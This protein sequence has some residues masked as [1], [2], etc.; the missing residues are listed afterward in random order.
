MMIWA[1]ILAP[2][3]GSAVATYLAIVSVARIGALH[4]RWSAVLGWLAVVLIGSPVIWL[5]FRQ[6]EA[7]AAAAG[8][9]NIGVPMVYAGLWL[10]SFLGSLVGLAAYLLRIHLK[11]E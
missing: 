11:S 2:A 4:Y 3:V 9:S 7:E 5:M 8:M 6:A 1:M 10:V